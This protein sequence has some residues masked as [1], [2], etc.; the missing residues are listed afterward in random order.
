M[1][2]WRKEVLA[3][4]GTAEAAWNQLDFDRIASL[5]E[6][7]APDL[8]YIAEEQDE[9]MFEWAA[10]QAY[11]AATQ[12]LISEIRLTIGE[13]RFA[14]LSDDLVRTYFRMAWRA[15]I[16]P[17]AGMK[18]IGMELKVVTLFRQRDSAWRLIQWV[19]SPLAPLPFLRRI[20]EQMADEYGA[21]RRAD[22][23]D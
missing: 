4:L 22:D 14:R 23:R 18:P 6:A 17:A 7:E 9:P 16:R 3:Q 2:D 15:E 20:Y 21:P 8:L 12:K 11:W 13:P 1:T 5:W 19:E 10:I